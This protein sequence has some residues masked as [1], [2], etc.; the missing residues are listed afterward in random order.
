MSRLRTKSQSI[1]S[2]AANTMRAWCHSAGRS[3][4]Q[5][6][7]AKGFG[8]LTGPGVTA[9]A[10]TPTPRAYSPSCLSQRSSRADRTVS[11]VLT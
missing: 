1:A 2:S 8:L 7:G 4:L 9:S 3:P 10:K 6:P 11:Y 5:P